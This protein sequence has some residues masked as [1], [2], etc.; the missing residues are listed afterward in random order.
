VFPIIFLIAIAVS[1]HSIAPFIVGIIIIAMITIIAKA[2]A[3]T[4][5]KN[6]NMNMPPMGQMPYQQPQQQYYQP[7]QQPYQQYDQGY[8]AAQ[9][10]YPSPEP[11]YQYQPKPEYDEQPQVQYPQELPPIKQQ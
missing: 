2:I 1:N 3:S 8:Q 11:S 6:G 10:P 4:S 9:T 5:P 7:P